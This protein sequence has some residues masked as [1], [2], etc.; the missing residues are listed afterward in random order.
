MKKLQISYDQHETWMQSYR[1]LF[2]PH[3]RGEYLPS[4]GEHFVKFFG[5]KNKRLHKLQDQEKA[6]QYIHDNFIQSDW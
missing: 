4:I 1:D 5:I 6:M 2:L 3:S